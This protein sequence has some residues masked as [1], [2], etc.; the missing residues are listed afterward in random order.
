MVTTLWSSP[1]G[2]YPMITTLWYLHYDLPKDTYTLTSLGS[3]TLWPDSKMQPAA[4]KFNLELDPRNRVSFQ[5]REKW[6]WRRNFFLEKSQK[7]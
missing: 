5:T 6:S 4:K 2:P 1:Y 7:F 3:F